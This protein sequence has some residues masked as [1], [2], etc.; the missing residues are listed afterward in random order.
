MTRGAKA[1][2]NRFNSYTERN[3][4]KRKDI[5]S[6]L[7]F[8]IKMEKLIFNSITSM[9]KYL[10]KR[11]NEVTSKGKH[12]SNTTILRNPLYRTLLT[13]AYNEHSKSISNIV[14]S[15]QAL[16]LKLD[17]Y[18]LKRKLSL[19]NDTIIN[20]KSEIS[21]KHHPLPI[22]VENTMKSLDACYK[23]IILLIEKSNGVF[24]MNDKGIID[25]SNIYNNIIVPKK[26]LETSNILNY[27][28]HI[29]IS[30]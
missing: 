10:A 12:I 5:L 20:I 13:K 25:Q 19:A 9:S 14:S 4:L 27:Q 6:S 21:E 17:N 29:K 24:I 7:I 3:I 15:T 26:L 23:I 8:E 18:N 2:E 11:F 1:G 22:D 30:D 16:E 28:Y